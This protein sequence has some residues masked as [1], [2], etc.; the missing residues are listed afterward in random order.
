MR[1]YPVIT[2]YKFLEYTLKPLGDS[3]YQERVWINHEGKE[4]DEYDEAVMHFMD[5]CEEMLSYPDY[6]EGMNEKIQETLQELYDKV[7]KFDD[8]IAS[9]FP[10]GKENE[11]IYTPEWNEVQR[12]TSRA[13]TIIKTNLKERNYDCKQRL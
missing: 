7:C 8:K 5:R 4:V 10:E 1:M 2:L 13:Y 12:F 3:A 9:K 6:Y 11:V